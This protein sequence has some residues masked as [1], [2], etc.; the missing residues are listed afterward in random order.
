MKAMRTRDNSVEEAMDEQLSSLLDGE[1]SERELNRLVVH[2]ETDRAA[3]ARF[4]RFAQISAFLGSDRGQMVDASNIAA[5]VSAALENEP[6]ILAPRQW[7]DGLRL[8]RLALGAAL[9]AGVAAMAVAIAPQII[10]GHKPSTLPQTET[11][12]FTPRMSVPV[13]GLRTVALQANPHPVVIRP[14]GTVAE[15]GH[16]RV[17]KPGMRERLNRYLLQHNEVAGHIATQQPSAYVS[18][19]SAPDASR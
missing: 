14:S 1:L 19:V 16:W 18:F 7:R 15:A 10:G 2:L 11:F 17:L 3:R 12:A 13:D 5:R 8:P 9:A 6:T 4:G